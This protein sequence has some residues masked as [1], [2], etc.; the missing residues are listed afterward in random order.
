MLKKRVLVFYKTNRILFL[1]I[2]CSFYQ[3]INILSDLFRFKNCIFEF[4]IMISVT[5]FSGSVFFLAL[6]VYCRMFRLKLKETQR[7]N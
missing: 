5:L 1:A 6:A 7:D 4:Q 3:T 2:T